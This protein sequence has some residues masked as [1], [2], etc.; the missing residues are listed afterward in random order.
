MSY[1]SIKITRSVLYDRNCNRQLLLEFVKHDG[2]IQHGISGRYWVD[3]YEPLSLVRGTI[4]RLLEGN[5]LEHMQG[6]VTTAFWNLGINYRGQRNLSVEIPI[7]PKQHTDVPHYSCKMDQNVNHNAES[8]QENSVSQF[9]LKEKLSVFDNKSEVFKFFKENKC[10]VC[11]S[12]Y[13]EILDEDLHIV[14][15]SCGHPLCCKCADN[16]LASENKECPQC[17]ENLTVNS[18]NLMNFN[19]DLEI[20][21]KNQKLF[22]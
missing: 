8:T 12:N 3:K 13:K 2:S 14:I 5:G 1:K 4:K 6:K 17:R 21:T 18:F 11:I 9:E 19:A 22:L 15:P 7:E 16:I 20:L 10:P